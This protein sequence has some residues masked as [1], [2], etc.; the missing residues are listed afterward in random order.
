M[1]RRQ[2]ARA[3]LSRAEVAAQLRVPGVVEGGV[4]LVHTSFRAVQPVE[5]GPLG[6]TEALEA[7]AVF[8][9]DIARLPNNGWGR[10]GL[11]R[12]LELQDRMGEARAIEQQFDAAWS[13]ADL[14]MKSPCLCLPGL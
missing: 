2:Q 1:T 10:Y 7:E 13:K 9:E 3:E 4:L 5:L 8:R 6:L 14:A 12:A 11:M